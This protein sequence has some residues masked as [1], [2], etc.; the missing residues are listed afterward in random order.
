[1]EDEDLVLSP[2]LVPQGLARWPVVK[3]LLAMQELQG[4]WV[5]S[6]G[7][8]IPWR[9]VWQPTSVFL[10]G[11]SHGQRSLVGYSPWGHNESDTT[12]VT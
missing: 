9:G 1:M 7:G 4:A 11:E 10:P 5:Q 6:L 12:K 3:N 8:K 2:A